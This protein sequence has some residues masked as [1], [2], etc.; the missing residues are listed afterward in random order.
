MVWVLYAMLRREAE[1]AADEVAVKSG[2]QPSEY[3]QQLVAV[4][5]QYR[6]SNQLF[7]GSV[8][9]ATTNLEHRVDA[10]LNPQQSVTRSV[11]YRRLLTPLLFTL[12]LVVSSIRFE[13]RAAEPTPD[14][15]AN[16]VSS[17]L[18]DDAKSA[19]ARKQRE[20]REEAARQ[21]TVEL[22]KRIADL[23]PL[24]YVESDHKTA[25][26]QGH[27]ALWSKW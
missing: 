9:M 7:A 1:L 23:L 10:V 20:S 25:H 11:W 2:I 24:V 13:S 21:S 15:T 27:R 12:P 8:S 14:E 26:P 16:V 18:F 22:R 3:A 4:V 17:P 5:R 6:P 19:A